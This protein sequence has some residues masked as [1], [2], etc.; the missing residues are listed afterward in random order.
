MKMCLR[1]QKGIFNDGLI[2]VY[3]NKQSRKHARTHSRTHPSPVTLTQSRKYIM[4]ITL[5]CLIPLFIF[6]E[7]PDYTKHAIH[8][9]NQTFTYEN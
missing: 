8:K 2:T 7:K 5:V 9:S 4:F 6:H 3:A 1:V